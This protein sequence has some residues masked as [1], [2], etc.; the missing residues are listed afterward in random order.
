MKKNIFNSSNTHILKYNYKNYINIPILYAPKSIEKIYEINVIKKLLKFNYSKHT[1]VDVGAHIGFYSILYSYFFKNVYAFEPS[2]FQSQY[3]KHNQK[4][5]KIK[6]L[7][8]FSLG[9]GDKNI[10]KK[11][12]VMGRS[13]GN[14]TFINDNIRNFNPMFS[15][16]VK[17]NKLDMFELENVSLIKIDV[18]GFELKVILGALSTIKRC[19]PI[20]I[21]EISNQNTSKKLIQILKKIGYNI[22]YPYKYVQELAFCFCEEDKINVKFL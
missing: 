21:V 9:L 19:K 20:I 6:N 16:D 17:L 4:I 14:N 18:E 3:L 22:Y 11:L 8:I 12:F 1:F 15:Y 2:I 7:K 5:N 13:G 10:K